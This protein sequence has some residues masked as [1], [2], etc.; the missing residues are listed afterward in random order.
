MTPV[1]RKPRHDPYRFIHKG[2]RAALCS[3]LLALGQA[4]PADDAELK[5]ALDGAEE[6]IALLLEHMRQENHFFHV[7][8]EARQPGA[9][10]AMGDEHTELRDVL[11]D[12]QEDLQRLRRTVPGGRAAQLHWLYQRF[13]AM[14]AEGME[15]MQREEN[16]LNAL[17]WALYTDDELVA[18][19]HRLLASSETR[20]LRVLFCWMAQALAPRELAALVAV[21]RQVATAADFDALAGEAQQRLDPARWGRLEPLLP[22]AARAHAG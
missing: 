4:D 16:E 1:S 15:H 2:L 12:L 19:H 8:L 10:K 6:L 18:I 9:S 13:C 22:V 7:A 5:A 20:L 3:T 14:A 21:M 17:L 11:D